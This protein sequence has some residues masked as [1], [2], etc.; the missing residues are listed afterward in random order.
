MEKVERERGE[1]GGMRT[2]DV[3]KSIVETGDGREG[4]GKMRSFT[5]KYSPS[6]SQLH[7]LLVLTERPFGLACRVSARLVAV[8][9]PY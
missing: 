4:A 9:V 7:N 1:G 2:R 6:H 3:N 5:Y 8:A